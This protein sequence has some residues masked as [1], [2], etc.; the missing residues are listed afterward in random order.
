VRYH[1]NWLKAYLNYTSHAESPTPFHFW[2]GVG[3]IAGALRRQVWIDQSTFQWTPN[4]YIILVGP[5]GVAAKSTS[6]RQGVALLEQVEDIVFGP[7]SLTWHALVELLQNAQRHVDIPGQ[8]DKAVMSCATIAASELGTLLDPS[9]RELIDVLV[10]M[11]DGQLSTWRRKTKTSGDTVIFNPWLNILAC[12]TP[13][14]LRA[15]FPEEMVGGGF[16]SRVIFVHGDRKRQLVA[17][18]SELKRPGDYKNEGVTLAADLQVI[19]N[20]RGE[21]TLTPEAIQWG[22]SW[23]ASLWD[24]SQRGTGIASERFDGYIARK[25]AHV[26][27]LAIVLA[28]SKRND[29]RIE[30]EDLREAEQFVTSLEG[31]MLKV[32]NSIGV[33]EEA[34][35]ANAIL[36]LIRSHKKIAYKKL[37]QLC[38]VTMAPDIFRDGVRSAIEAGYVR[39][40][41][42]KGEIILEALDPEP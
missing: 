3:T 37:W 26:H 25:Q 33:A 21:Y 35:K 19:A 16:T 2:T 5:P 7:T 15:N 36:T 32:F 9:N 29:L 13:A 27:K 8:P 41:N 34:T 17:Y 40:L 12:T 38:Y 30:L 28:A 6:L 23:Y 4:F 24:G 11:W 42:E 1:K 20:L 22:T 39:Q 18:P 31:D 10:D 14:W